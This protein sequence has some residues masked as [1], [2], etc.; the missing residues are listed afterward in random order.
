MET[1]KGEYPQVSKSPSQN[2]NEISPLTCYNGYY[3]RMRNNMLVRIWRKDNH[4]AL[5]VGMLI[6]YSH[7]G[8]QYGGSSKK[9]KCDPPFHF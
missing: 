8:K 7:Y 1:S 4:S 6:V 5:L 3:Q 2:H 9:L